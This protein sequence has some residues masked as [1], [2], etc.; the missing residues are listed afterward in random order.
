VSK[1]LNEDMAGPND[2]RDM[3]RRAGWFSP[4]ADEAAFVR[5]LLIVV[6][7]GGLVLLAWTLSSVFLLAFGAVVLAIALRSLADLFVRWAR[8]PRRFSLL[9]ASLVML[10]VFAGLG[11]F[12]G[13]Q[14]VGQFEQLARQIPATLDELLDRIGLSTG[15]LAEA[16]REQAT[17]GG[18]LAPGIASSLATA[19]VSLAA[20]LTNF[21][22]IVAAGV[23]LA[24][25]P[26]AYLGGVRQLFPRTQQ[27]RVTETLGAVGEALRLWLGGAVVSMTI[28][29][30]LTG[31][32]LWAVGVPYAFALGITAGLLEFIPYVGP[33]VAGIVALLAALSASGNTVLWALGV[34][35]VIQQVESYLIQP[36]V[37][38]RAVQL[39]PALGILAIVGFGLAFGVLGVIFAA[40]LTVALYVA[41]KKLYVRETLGQAT[42]VPGEE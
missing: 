3:P 9:A 42:E 11:F 30:M 1:G 25:A 15:P 22:L 31:F 36:L 14:I 27:D 7:I 21:L 23:Y 17:H 12:F 16:A 19:G 5:R 41:V 35:I 40:P 4:Y 18:G 29:A 6:A 37:Q 26:D 33:L 13:I 10:G 8:V 24:V 2:D 20:G 32:G 34:V 38:E 28:V 39:P